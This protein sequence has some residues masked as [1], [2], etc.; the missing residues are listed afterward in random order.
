MR[1]ITDVL[2]DLVDN[3][4]VRSWFAAAV[5]AALGVLAISGW[6][7]ARRVSSESF[8]RMLQTHRALNEASRW[9]HFAERTLGDLTAE[10]VRHAALMD[11]VIA[12]PV[13]NDQY[14]DLLRRRNEMLARNGKHGKDWGLARAKIA[15]AD[16]DN[17]QWQLQRALDGSDHLALRAPMP[18]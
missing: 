14:A 2:F 16:L 11:A 7:E 4:S 6:S 5:I 8:D 17:Y 3:A 10:E 9:K 12:S 13:S 15:G 1:K 18:K